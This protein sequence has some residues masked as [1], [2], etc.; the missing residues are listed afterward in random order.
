MGTRHLIAVVRDGKF[1][2]AQYGQW[3][4]YPSGQGLYI[5]RF[6]RS[7]QEN[8]L[9]KFKQQID[10]CRFVTGTELNE[11]YAPFYDAEGYM[12]ME[13]HN[14][15]MQSEYSYLSR[16]TGA[17]ILKHIANSDSESIALVDASDFA[18]DSLHCEWAYVVD[19]DNEIFEVYEGFNDEGP[20]PVQNKF[21]YLNP[22]EKFEPKY[23]GQGQ[24]FP[25][26]LRATYTFD[27]LPSD[28]EFVDSLSCCEED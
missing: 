12:D 8:G 25:C 18:G 7:A 4:G 24:Y 5:L 13:Q 6:L 1:K 16:D 14:R 23:S 28:D 15:F 20:V 9:D 10:K 17:Q 27:H 11:I 19:L 3:D 2:V 22:T 26:K 21:A